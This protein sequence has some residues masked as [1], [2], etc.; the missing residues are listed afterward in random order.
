MRMLAALLLVGIGLAG[1]ANRSVPA[2][3]ENFIDVPAKFDGKVM[4]DDVADKMVVLFPPARTSI[5][6]RQTTLD[7][8][9]ATLAAALR[10]KG[11]ALAEFDPSRRTLK[12]EAGAP[13]QP[14][15]T[16]N[17]ALAY[18]VDQ[19]MEAGLYRVTVLINYQSLSRLYQAKDGSLVPAG[20]WVRKE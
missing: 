16:D 15:A 14:Q 13:V 10:G 4:A 2:T 18:L 8:F 12:P 17:I 1:C 6:M 7:A 3:Y 19:P 20:Y 9:G 5:K 11:Y